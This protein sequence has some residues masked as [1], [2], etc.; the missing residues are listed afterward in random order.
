[1]NGPDTLILMLRV[2]FAVINVDFLLIFVNY[3]LIYIISILSPFVNEA[4]NVLIMSC[5]LEHSKNS[6][7][8]S[9]RY[10]M[11]V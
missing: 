3:I 4:N 11:K 7:L 9:G 6:P 1:M 2:K 10:L 8:W 5:D